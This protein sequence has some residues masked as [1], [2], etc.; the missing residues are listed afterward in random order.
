MRRKLVGAQR[1]G[2]KFVI[3]LNR[4]AV[5]FKEEWTAGT[6]VFDTS[7]IFDRG[8]WKDSRTYY[9]QIIKDEENY[10]DE[11]NMGKYHM[12]PGFEIIILS[13][14]VSEE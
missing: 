14:Y 11:I 10:D 6:K 4:H 9:M 1:C 8:T 7:R 3:N 5:D 13:R 12:K 2:K